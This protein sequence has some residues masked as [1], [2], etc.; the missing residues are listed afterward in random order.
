MAKKAKY[1][2]LLFLDADVL[3]VDNTL[4]TG[5]LP[6]LNNEEKIIYGG[7]KYQKKTPQSKQILRWIYG[8]E[9]ESLNAYKRSSEPYL[10]LLT[11]NF[12]INK[13]I[14][15]KVSFNETIPNLRYED[16]LFSYELSL[17]KI[18]VEHIN[19]PVYHLGLDTSEIFLV[20]T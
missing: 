12:T 9:R 14:F 19:N 13:S 3:P 4:I 2:W 8:N 18:K 17:K 6:F 15:T 10:S 7:I 5:Y 11:L 1:S 20:K 16:V